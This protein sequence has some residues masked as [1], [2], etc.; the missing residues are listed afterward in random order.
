MNPLT[1]LNY[2]QDLPRGPINDILATLAEPLD[3]VDH[4]PH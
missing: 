3:G 2:G 1:P 4:D